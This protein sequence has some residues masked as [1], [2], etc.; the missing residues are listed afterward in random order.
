MV[1]VTQ[2]VLDRWGSSPER[3]EEALF[4]TIYHERRRIETSRNRRAAAR[5]AA[6]YDEV[7]RRALRAGADEQ[8]RLLRRIIER[9]AREVLGHFDERVYRLATRVVP[10][11]LSLLRNTVSPLR[12]IETLMPG[13][14]AA[15]CREGTPRTR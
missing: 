11:G 9:F 5:Q 12:M 6:F 10:A 14:S 1:E 15:G 3:T 7:Y 2:R 13:C 8:H 4:E